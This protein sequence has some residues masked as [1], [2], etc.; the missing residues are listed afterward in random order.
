MLGNT[1]LALSGG[2]LYKISIF[3]GFLLFVI[4]LWIVFVFA[5]PFVGSV[6]IGICSLCVCV[7][8]WGVNY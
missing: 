6:C 2:I 1:F 8:F 5:H 4:P 7:A 3:D